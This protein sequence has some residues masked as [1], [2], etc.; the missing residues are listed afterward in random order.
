MEMK[1]ERWRGWN[2]LVTDGVGL[3][4]LR[5]DKDGNVVEAGGAVISQYPIMSASDAEGLARSVADWIAW[6][7]D[8]PG[9]FRG[10]D[11]HPQLRERVIALAPDA[12]E[13]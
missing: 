1:L 11:I 13:Q 10:A 9:E 8:E 7:S 5:L 2:V 4:I 6:V 3:P 12:V